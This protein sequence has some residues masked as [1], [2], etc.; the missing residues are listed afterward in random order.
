[1]AGRVFAL[2]IAALAA[3][4]PNVSGA[5]GFTGIYVFGDSLT[6]TG[7]ACSSPC[8]GY[9]VP[10]YYSGRF[11]NGPVWIEG[12]ATALGLS[13]SPS[14]AGGNNY[15]VG[16]AT[17][18]DVSASQVPDYLLDASG[19]ADPTGLYVLMAGGNDGLGGGSAGTAAAS[20]LAAIDDLKAAGAQYLFVSNLPDLSLTPV[21]FGNPVAQQFSLDFNAALAVG[22]SSLTGITLYE[23]DFYSLVNDTVAHPASYGFS[24]VDSACWDGVAVCANPNEYLFWDRL[25]PTSTAHEWIAS[26]AL[27]AVPEPGS[28]VL[29]FLGLLILSTR[30]ATR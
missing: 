24:N 21:A 7:N 4:L 15:A 20:M 22:L 8:P 16:G 19:A 5:V 26:A 1:M 28:C 17:T 23:F 9:P 14:N 6:D 10:P 2:W 3:T 27:L 29:V 11:S 25:H 30:R 18:V 13:L 12:V